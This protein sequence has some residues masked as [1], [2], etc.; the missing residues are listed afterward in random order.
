MYF[1]NAWKAIHEF[2]LIQAFWENVAG[3]LMARESIYL[4][5]QGLANIWSIYGHWLYP[6]WSIDSTW[7]HVRFLK[8]DYCQGL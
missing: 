6:K 1:D 5:Q 4:V 8:F 2:Q 3:L 7:V